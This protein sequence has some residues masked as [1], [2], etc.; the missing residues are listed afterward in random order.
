MEISPVTGIRVLPVVKVPPADS[1]LSRVFDIE[2]AARSGDDTYSGDGKRT[3]GGQDDESEEGE[4]GREEEPAE[5]EGEA[6]GQ[7]NFFA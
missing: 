2:N 1:D 4:E 6:V 5:T 3:S 7:I